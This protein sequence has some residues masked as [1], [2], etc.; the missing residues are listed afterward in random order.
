MRE[1]SIAGDDSEML[2]G[3]REDLNIHLC[4]ATGDDLRWSFDDEGDA[5]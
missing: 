4:S 1:I 3:V 2:Q 5:G